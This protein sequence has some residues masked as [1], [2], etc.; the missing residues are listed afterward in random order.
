M[1]GSTAL[2][3][4]PQRL[5]RLPNRRH[6]NVVALGPTP[7][8]GRGY[9]F[10]QRAGEFFRGEH[11]LEFLRVHVFPKP[12]A[13]QQETVAL[14]NVRRLHFDLRPLQTAQVAKQ[15]I[16]SRVGSCF[17]FGQQPLQSSQVHIGV[18]HRSIEILAIPK[19]V[20][21]TVTNVGPGCL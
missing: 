2:I 12:I 13:A 17:F 10:A 21:P 3:N 8:S 15:P 4:R 6:R 16:P 19:T 1:G 20:K 9:E 14:G 11:G 18:I 7:G 5:S